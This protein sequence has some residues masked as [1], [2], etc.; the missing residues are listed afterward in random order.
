MEG[1]AALVVTGLSK[2]FRG[3]RVK[4]LDQVS[5]EARPGETLGII[6]PNGAG[7]TTLMGCLLGLLRPE[8]GTIRFAEGAPDSFA[9]RA[10][11]GYLP[12]RLNFDRWMT[13]WKFVAFHHALMRR[14]PADRTREVGEVLERVGLQTQAWRVPIRGY[15]RGMLQRVGLAQAILGSPR[16]LLLDEPSSGVDPAGVLQIRAVLGSLKQQGT[17]ILLNSHQLDQVERL[18]DRVAMVKAGRIES[19]EDLN[20]AS[21]D[22][23]GRDVEIRWVT[24]PPEPLPSCRALAERLGGALA[25]LEGSRAT[26]HVPN[27]QA[28]AALVRELSNAG[29]A[30]VGVAETESRLERHFAERKPA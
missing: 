20:A 25:R 30:V 13:G 7:K 14:P 18:S 21:E 26:F 29:F 11:T 27:E 4:A 1:N 15:S 6:G 9:V 5:L 8:A 17:T 24:A 23:G 12:E 10:V 3:G 19:V 16:Y 22:T 2:S 28:I